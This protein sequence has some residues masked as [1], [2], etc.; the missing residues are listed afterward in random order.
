MRMYGSCLFTDDE[1]HITEK[2][3]ET[4]IM[5][6]WNTRRIK[7]MRKKPIVIFVILLLAA[8]AVISFCAHKTKSPEYALLQTIQD[9]KEQGYTGL[10][11]HV[12]ADTYDEIDRWFTNPFV[13]GIISFASQ[14]DEI[15]SFRDNFRNV[16]WSVEDILEGDHQAEIVVG[17]RYGNEISGTIKVSMIRENGNWIIDGV[18]IPQFNKTAENT[19]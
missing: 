19:I 6:P 14:T 18:G 10:K 17:F 5:V 2:P 11:N 9:V 7:N 1:K 16:D 8:G 3:A 15:S 13:S 12:A 4:A